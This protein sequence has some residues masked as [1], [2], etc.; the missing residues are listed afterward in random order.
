[1]V[2]RESTRSARDWP[3][4]VRSAS[5]AIPP[6]VESVA[7]LP[8]SATTI[9][10]LAPN[11]PLPRSDPNV[12]MPIARMT[13]NAITSAAKLPTAT[14]PPSQARRHERCGLALIAIVAIVPCGCVG[15]RVPPGVFVG[16]AVY[17]RCTSR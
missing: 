13:M 17:A 15:A 14:P 1:M 3:R 2:A 11:V 16:V 9:V 10:S 5:A 7:G 4:S 12:P 6:S 8:K